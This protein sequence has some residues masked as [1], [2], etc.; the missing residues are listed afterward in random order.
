MMIPF[1]TMKVENW[2]GLVCLLGSSLSLIAGDVQGV[3]ASAAFIGSEIILTYKGETS[4]GYSLGH[5]V[6]C[7]GEGCLLFSSVT[8]GNHNVQMLTVFYGALWLTASLRYPVERMAQLVASSEK[9]RAFQTAAN[10]I[11]PLTSVV[12]LLG[13]LPVLYAAAFA[14]EHFNGIMFFATLMWG[15]ADILIGGGVQK[16]IYTPIKKL[17]RMMRLTSAASYTQSDKD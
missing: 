11:P 14:G 9:Q 2:G 1:S 12:S 16:C 7:L 15:T 4:G 8:A 6:A 13:R 10:I 17:A 5:A 3:A